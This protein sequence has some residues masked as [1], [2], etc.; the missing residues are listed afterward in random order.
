E[1]Y[2]LVNLSG[3]NAKKILEIADYENVDIEAIIDFIKKLKGVKKMS[4]EK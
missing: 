4:N 1:E 3:E 2:K